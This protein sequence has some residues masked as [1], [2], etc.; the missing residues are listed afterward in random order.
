MAYRMSWREA[1]KIIEIV[2]TIYGELPPKKR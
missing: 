2:K 1:K